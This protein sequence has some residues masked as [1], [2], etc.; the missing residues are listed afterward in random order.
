LIP[1]ETSDRQ[2]DSQAFGL[3]VLAGDA[4]DIVGWIAVC[5]LG[6]SVKRTLDLVEAEEKRTR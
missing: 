3:A 6:D 5:T 4:L 1:R 2:R